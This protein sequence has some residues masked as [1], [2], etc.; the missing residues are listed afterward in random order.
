MWA[1]ERVVPKSIE[2]DLKSGLRFVERVVGECLAVCSSQI[3]LSVKLGFITLL[4]SSARLSKHD[5]A[6][7]GCVPQAQDDVSVSEMAADTV[8]VALDVGGAYRHVS[9]RHE[10]ST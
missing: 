4:S 6:F 1:I 10:T 5:S 7:D 2:A 8:D 9:V 3:N